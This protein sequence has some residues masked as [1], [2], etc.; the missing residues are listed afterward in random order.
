MMRRTSVLLF[1]G[2]VLGLEGDQGVAAFERL[3]DLAV[4]ALDPAVARRGHLALHLH[5][6]DR[7]QGLTRM[8]LVTLADGNRDDGARHRRGHRVF[9]DRRLQGALDRVEDLEVPGAA[10]GVDVDGVM[11]DRQPDLLDPVAERE[12][13]R[14]P[15]PAQ[16]R[17]VGAAA[18][19]DRRVGA[20]TG[21]GDLGRV[22]AFGGYL[23][24][25][26]GLHSP[27]AASGSG[28]SKRW[29]K[30]G[31]ASAAAVSSSRASSGVTGA[32]TR[33][34]ACSSRKL[35]VVSPA[36]NAG[37]ASTRSR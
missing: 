2:I 20:A 9:A 5:A 18:D 7:D 34:S 22:P 31:L 21:D 3:A 15:D 16:V 30:R 33:S 12:L 19:P 24:S 11:V 36:A 29:S 17:L 14:P 27:I 4:D 26:Q 1:H 25:H 28:I 35:V 6:L 10:E 37:W 23:E 13:V 32:A 8:D